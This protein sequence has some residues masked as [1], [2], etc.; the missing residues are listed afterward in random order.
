MPDCGYKWDITEAAQFELSAHLLW[1][2]QE[3]DSVNV[4]FDNLDFGD[5]ESLRSRVGGRFNYA[6]SEHFTPYAGAYWEY[7]FDGEVDG[8]INGWRID[9]PSL[10]GSTGVGELGFTVKPVADGGMSID[11]GVQGYTGVREGVTGSL[12]MKYEF[13][14]RSS[15]LRCTRTTNS[16][17]RAVVAG[18]FFLREGGSL[19]FP[20]PGR[21]GD[22]RSDAIQTFV[23]FFLDLPVRLVYKA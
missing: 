22:R 5:A 17:T 14:A 4:Y 2:H 8:K 15:F 18:A 12:G 7:E 19:A 13:Y 6:V 20:P 10:Q 1:T 9:E 21:Q 16:C 23:V 11:L 3:G